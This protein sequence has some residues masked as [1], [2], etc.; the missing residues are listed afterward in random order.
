MS[1]NCDNKS[2]GVIIKKGPQF[3]L[4]KRINFPVAYAFVAGHCDGE[5][6][7]K[8][9]VAEAL[10]E[11]GITVTKLEKRLHERFKNPCKRDGGLGHEWTVFEATEWSGELK[12]SSDAK[13]ALWVS[14][15]KLTRLARRSDSFLI[16]HS[17]TPHRF[18][19]AKATRTLDADHD[20]QENPGLELVWLL[21]LRKIG[22]L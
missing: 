14:S 9:A 17:F 4:I 15:D 7:E 8:Q 19:L 22:I 13:E 16:K 1:K 21:M 6:F 18:D 11:G 20:W 3:A 5:T 2:V 12:A 10:E